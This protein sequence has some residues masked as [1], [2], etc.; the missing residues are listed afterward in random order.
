MKT[1]QQLKKQIKNTVNSKLSFN[2]YVM[3]Y[4]DTFS[5]L[6]KSYSN[7]KWGYGDE[8]LST[9]LSEKLCNDFDFGRD[10]GEIYCNVG[11]LSV[12]DV[13]ELDEWLGS[14]NTYSVMCDDDTDV[15]SLLEDYLQS[16]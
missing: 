15:D 6:Y 1:K 13:F 3:G 4:I 11:N 14:N 5:K 7:L 9:S 16:E 8:T 2:I 10:D 12:E